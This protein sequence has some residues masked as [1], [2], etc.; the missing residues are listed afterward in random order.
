MNTEFD[1]EKY[2][3]ASTHQREW[4][5]RL[6]AEL[7]L[8]GTERILDLGCGDGALTAQLA[9]LVRQGHV[10][11]IDSSP[12]MIDAARRQAQPN[13]T[14]ALC[15]INALA[16][17]GEFDLVFSNA[18]LHWV[19]DHHNLLRRVFR[20]LKEHGV[21]RCNFAAEGNCSNLNRIV[22]QVIS[23]TKFAP[24]FTGFLWPWHMPKVDDYRALVGQFPFR[25]SSVWG[26]QA[27][28]FFPDTD[29]MIRWIDQPSL[30][31][32]LGRIAAADRANFRAEV[33]EGMIRATRQRDGRCLETF[34][35]IN[36]FARR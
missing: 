2:R 8:K 17:E 20:S 3:H 16:W 4:G 14:F 28:H 1:G 23:Q 30:V 26:E 25:E 34:R 35:R 31:P 9:S 24:Y 32:F 7:Q 22:R 5:A 19:L 18:T 12:S 21:L 29:A 11:G 13:L 33:L 27:D 6:I 36:V 10:V 15:D